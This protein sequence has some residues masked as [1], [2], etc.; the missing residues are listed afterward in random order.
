MP[1][2][3]A[4]P[5]GSTPITTDAI[6]IDRLGVGTEY[7]LISDLLNAFL[8]GAP[9]DIAMGYSNALPANS[10]VL[11]FIATRN[12]TTANLLAGSRAELITGGSS[13]VTLFIQRNG[14]QF[15]TVTFPTGNSSVGVFTGTAQTFSAG[16]LLEVVTPAVTLGA[17]NL[18]IT[19][20]G[21]RIP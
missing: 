16:D 13:P 21:T 14:V 6:V 1:T 4:Y 9:Y 17:N 3:R 19:F 20:A 5:Y 11:N 2:F 12:F 18:A 8:Y 15:G 10:I 7:V